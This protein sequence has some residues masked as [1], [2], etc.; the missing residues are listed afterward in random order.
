MS[1]VIIYQKAKGLATIT[2]NRPEVLNA[3][4]M[5]TFSQLEA[6]V[7]DL[8][9]DP[10]V[11]IVLITG[12]GRAFCSGIDITFLN[13]IREMNSS[14]FR[15][16][17]RR[18]QEK[19]FKNLV[20]LEKPVI[21]KINGLALGA[22]LEL[23]LACDIRIASEEAK[24][25]LPEVNFGVIPDLGGIQRL[26]RLIGIGKAKELILTARTL[27]AKEAEEIGLVNKVFTP[28]RLEEET[29]K[30]IDDL[31]KKPPLT[32]G[33]A[34]LMIDKAI[35]VDLNSSLEEVIYIQNLCLQSEDHQ[36]ATSAFLEKRPPNFKGR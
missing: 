13:T 36:E 2:L 23:A 7:E 28:D 35:E 20:S 15:S 9:K 17:L 16:W 10:R 1:E 12:T 3:L 6:V 14:Q 32:L 8:Q 5:E 19:I 4:D 26:P 11:R 22:G 18:V 31:M 21:A 33:L 25:G 30:L 27:G 34:K 29:K 24:F